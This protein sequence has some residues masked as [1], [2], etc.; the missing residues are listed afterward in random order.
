MLSV[1][2]LTLLYTSYVILTLSEGEGEGSIF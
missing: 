1:V 2:F